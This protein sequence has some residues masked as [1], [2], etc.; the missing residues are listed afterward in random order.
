MKKV[1]FI[2]MIFI[3]FAFARATAGASIEISGQAIPLIEGSSEISVKA[4]E[5]VRARIAVY[6]VNGPLSET[7]QFYKS[8]FE[9]EGFLLLGGDEP[10]GSFNA[11]V[12]KDSCQFSIRIYSDSGAT[13]LQFTW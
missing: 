11:A 8:F 2:A 1:P 7:V 6:S 4:Q 13:R 12:K 3:L 10:D 5:T 9:A